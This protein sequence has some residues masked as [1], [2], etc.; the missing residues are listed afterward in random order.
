MP[1]RRAHPLAQPACRA[2]V[3]PPRR[4]SGSCRS[5]G[6]RCR[7]A[8]RGPERRGRS[9]GR[10]RIPSR[11]DAQV[12]ARRGDHAES[13][14]RRGRRSATRP[15]PPRR[16]AA[17][18]GPGRPTRGPSGRARAAPASC[19][20]MMLNRSSRSSPSS[21]ARVGGIEPGRG[22]CAAAASRGHRPARDPRAAP[23]S[24][25][26]PAPNPSATRSSASLAA[27]A[28]WGRGRRWTRR[29]GR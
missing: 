23:G 21:H 2:A 26:A 12:H 8:D 14:R 29:R 17:A 6:R 3:W 1:I 7:P 20:D 24:R 10:R 4:R 5:R 28:G 9:P 19:P 16:R 13:A 25:S 11:A 27:R 18:I 22:R 15:G